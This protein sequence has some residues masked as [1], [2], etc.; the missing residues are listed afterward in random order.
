ML[1]PLDARFD[2]IIYVNLSVRIV[3][4]GDIA[5]RG[6]NGV[7][8]VTAGASASALAVI[9]F[10][11]GASQRTVFAAAAGITFSH[12][13]ETAFVKDVA[14]LGKATDDVAVGVTVAESRSLRELILA[15][16][17]FI[18]GHR[19]LHFRRGHGRRVQRYDV[20]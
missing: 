17:T 20:G 2:M 6:R 16:A 7:G 15:D 14:T 10:A 18:R 13:L 11:E 19:R 8:H 5:K 1:G 4:S 9:G 3:E 12:R